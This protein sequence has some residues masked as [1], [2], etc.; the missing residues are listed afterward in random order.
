[1]ARPSIEAVT[2]ETLVEFAGFLRQHLEP[3]RSIED[4]VAGLRTEW[5]PTRPNYGYVLRDEGRIVGGIGAIY[6]SRAIRGRL[7]RFCNITSWCVLDEY[8]TQS[9]RLA[10]T[11]IGQKGFHF[12]DFSPTR[13]VASSLLF[14]KFRPLDDRQ[15]VLFNLP[16]LPRGRVLSSPA[17]IAHVLEGDALQA[18]RD[19]A[20]FPWLHHVALEAGE[21]WCHVIYKHTR[22]KGLKAAR[23]LH[24]SDR[25]VFGRVLRRLGGHLLSH[26]IVTTH[27]D[28]RQVPEVS[29]PHAVRKGFVPKVYLSESLGEADIDYL[30]S[31]SMA[32]DLI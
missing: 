6:A 11:V 19:H 1:M 22:Y 25:A 5:C 13:V 14:L 9:M 16:A 15:V 12:T 29:A 4:W 24:A 3:S 26:G 10:L 23:V 18:Y 17:A 8:R 27:V 7:E 21:G 32:F 31:E 28:Y 20:A 30:Y 2:D